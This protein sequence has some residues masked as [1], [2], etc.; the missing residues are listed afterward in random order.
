MSGRIVLPCLERTLLTPT[1]NTPPPLGSPPSPCASRGPKFSLKICAKH[2]RCSSLVSVVPCVPPILVKNSFGRRT[3]MRL[4]SVVPDTVDGSLST[5]QNQL[6]SSCL[7]ISDLQLSP[8]PHPQLI[9]GRSPLLS[10][11]ATGL[12][13]PTCIALFTYSCLYCAY[14]PSSST[15]SH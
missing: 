7:R 3:L 4:Y 11:I 9:R 10:P 6:R 13:L 5:A 15:I 2:R 1:S 8:P 14:Q 12:S